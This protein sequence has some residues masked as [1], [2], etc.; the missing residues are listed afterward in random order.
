MIVDEM[1]VWGANTKD[2]LLQHNPELKVT[3]VGRPSTHFLLNNNFNL[4]LESPTS[5]LAILDADEFDDTNEKILQVVE[6]L[7]EKY[8]INFFIKNHP[9]NNLNDSN[10]EEYILRDNKTLGLN[11]HFVGYRS[12]LLLELAADNFSCFV[13]E[14]SPFVEGQGELLSMDIYGKR[15]EM[16]DV[17]KYLAYTSKKA[18]NVF[19]KEI[20]KLNANLY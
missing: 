3:I 2:L 9:S 7:A 8:G 17:S 16:N 1:F 10:L 20:Q 5:Y 12:S 6:G 4:A 14:E 15:L 11:P 19:F 18:E 13:L